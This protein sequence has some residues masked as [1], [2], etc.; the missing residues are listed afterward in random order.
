M[1]LNCPETIHIRYIRNPSN[2]TFFMANTWCKSQNGFLPIPKS[3]VENDW[4][5]SL[6]NT[7]LGSSLTNRTIR[8]AQIGPYHEIFTDWMIP[9]GSVPNTIETPGHAQLT[10]KYGNAGDVIGHGWRLTDTIGLAFSP[11]T[12]YLPLLGKFPSLG[13]LIFS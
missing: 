11:A 4:L 3:L 13:K 12:C 7:W 9:D 2:M 10:E 1:T 6:G 5:A 8:Y